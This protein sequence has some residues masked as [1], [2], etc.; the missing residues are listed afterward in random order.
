MRNKTNGIKR[1][2]SF[3]RATAGTAIAPLSQRN[4][5]RLS[6]RPSYGWISQKRCKLRLPNFY[7]LL[8]GRI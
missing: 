2:C 1:R 6:V 4:S 7:R 8:L 3:L 5:V